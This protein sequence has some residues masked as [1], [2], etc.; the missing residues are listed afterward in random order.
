MNTQCA[1]CFSSSFKLV[2]PSN[3]NMGC[4][5]CKDSMVKHTR[6]LFPSDNLKANVAHHM[7][8]L[9]QREPAVLPCH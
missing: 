4:E 7:V 9:I 8:E 1:R 6:R 2:R 5:F 3:P